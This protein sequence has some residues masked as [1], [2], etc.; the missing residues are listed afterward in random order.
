MG[1]WGFRGL[2]GWF[3]YW[4][5]G[6]EKFHFWGV[7]RGLGIWGC[8]DNDESGIGSLHVKHKESQVFIEADSLYICSRLC[9]LFQGRRDS[10]D[11]H[12]LDGSNS[13]CSSNVVLSP[14]LSRK[15]SATTSETSIALCGTP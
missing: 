10:F 13:I 11:L 1:L 14:S 6:W 9:F 5:C 12:Y 2:K 15:L 4:S 8:D 7:V 3:F